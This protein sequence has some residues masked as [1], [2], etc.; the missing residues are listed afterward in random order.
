M[1][2]PIAHKDLLATR[3]IRTTGG[4]RLHE[5][6]V[7]DHDAVVVARLAEA[8]TVL[9]GKTN[10]HELGGGVTTI[11]PFFG[12]THNPHDRTRI[13]GGSSG[14]SA[15]AVAAR[16]VVAATGSDTGGSVR[17]PAALCGCVGL[18][19][20][21]GLVDT[22]GLLGACP[23]FDHVGLCTRS[24]ADAA[25]LLAAMAGDGAAAA[26][27][28]VAATNGSVAGLRVGVPR[29]YFFDGVE[30]GVARAV[31]AAL[32]RLRGHGAIVRDVA[33]ALP[34]TLYDTMFAPIAVSEIRRTYAADWAAR[35]DAFSGDFAAVFAG[36]GPAAAEVEHARQARAAFERTVTRL[37][38]DVDVLAMPT[39]P[40]VAPPI[41]GAIDGMRVLRNTWP[42]NAARGPAI[43]VPCGSGAD[44]LP[45]GLQ[46]VAAPHA[47]ATLLRAAAAA[48]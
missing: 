42:F 22:T 45:V 8:G 47:E 14:G 31:D 2:V 24:V 43:S 40:M 25:Y 37:F 15:A 44:G 48:A 46:L 36:P 6:W 39:V 33:L 28:Y 4:S 9:L 18:K 27:D 17:I 10:T 26:P 21:F 19:P 7:P 23:T 5:R 32:D 3:G 35:P 1:G 12:T 20:T 29:A 11:N 13:A 38:D 34:T 30:P 41:E 16:L